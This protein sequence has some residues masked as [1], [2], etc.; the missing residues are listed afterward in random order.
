MGISVF[1]AFPCQGT[2]QGQN[3]AHAGEAVDPA[4]AVRPVSQHQ[5]FQQP[6]A[7]LEGF[8]RPGDH[9]VDKD[10]VHEALYCPSLREAANQPAVRRSASEFLQ[11]LLPT[12]ESRR[13]REAAKQPAKQTYPFLNRFLQSVTI[14]FIIQYTRKVVFSE[15]RSRVGLSGKCSRVVFSGKMFVDYIFLKYVLAV[16]LP[17]KRSWTT[18]F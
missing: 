1:Q 11:P 14:V 9:S 12:A 8:V 7:E 16:Y 13:E 17:E 3:P 18:F 4:R 6:T 5:L 2:G 15:K 10:L